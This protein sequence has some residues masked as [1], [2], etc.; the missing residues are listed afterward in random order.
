MTNLQD[1]PD[2]NV[3]YEDI[4]VLQKEWDDINDKIR[5][6]TKDFFIVYF[7]NFQFE[8]KIQIF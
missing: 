3:T 4:L 5:D 8:L 7:P 2:L 1:K 6:I